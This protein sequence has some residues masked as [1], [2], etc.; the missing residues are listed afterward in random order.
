MTDTTPYKYNTLRKER[1]K[2]FNFR[3]QM[4]LTAQKKGIRAT[5]KLFGTTRVTVRKWLKRYHA[6]GK[7]GLLDKSSRPKHSPN[8]LDLSTRLEIKKL[9][10]KTW[11]GC[12]RM[13][14]EFDLPYAPQT[15]NK[16]FHEY[17]LI[18][19]KVKKHH[20]KNDLRMEKAKKYKPLRYF[21]MDVKY[22]YDIPQYYRYMIEYRLPK[23]QYTIREVRSGA[24][25]LGF[26]KE[27]STSHATIFI[28]RFLKHLKSCGI[29]LSEVII[30]TDNGTEFSGNIRSTPQHGFSYLIQ[31]GYGATHRF[32]PPGCCNANADVE[33]VHA[34]IE[35]EFFDIERFTYPH[36]F[37]NKIST[38]QFYFNFFRKNSYKNWQSPLE[39]VN[40]WLPDFDDQAFFDFYPIDLDKAFS[41]TIN[42]IQW[43]YTRSVDCPTTQK[44]EQ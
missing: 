39:L 10:E 31:S 24:L 14:R 41:H 34:L 30:Q 2:M 6:Y 29:P 13:K 16:V 3:F 35:N 38:Y 7:K 21:Q 5:S 4:V 26:S 11:I 44:N 20:K 43:G 19:R 18:K 25:F 12:H 15:I 22:L 28:N 40:L 33:T 36:Q 32:I 23:Y 17:A 42:S 1:C 8:K 27:L 37:W 9:R